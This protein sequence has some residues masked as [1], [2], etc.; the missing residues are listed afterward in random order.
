[1]KRSIAV[2]QAVIDLSHDGVSQPRTTR[3]T[4]KGSKKWVWPSFGVFRVFRGSWIFGGSLPK[5]VTAEL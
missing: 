5:C 2:W 4:R 3:K 1:M